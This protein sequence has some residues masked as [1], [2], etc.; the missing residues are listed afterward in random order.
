MQ[1]LERGQTTEYTGN[2]LYETKGESFEHAIFLI[3]HHFS[4]DVKYNDFIINLNALPILDQW[5]KLKR[6]FGEVKFQNLMNEYINGDY[7]NDQEFED[8]INGLFVHGI[9]TGELGEY[10]FGTNPTHTNYEQVRGAADVFNLISSEPVTD[11]EISYEQQREYSLEQMRNNCVYQ[12]CM[13]LAG[14]TNVNMNKYWVT[15][16]ETTMGI[17]R[18]TSNTV[19][20][21]ENTKVKARIILYLPAQAVYGE[22]G[23]L[24]NGFLVK[25]H[26]SNVLGD[27]DPQLRFVKASR[28]E[29]M[30]ER[31]KE[32]VHELI[33]DINRT[34]EPGNIEWAH[35]K[36]R[37]AD[38][39]IDIYVPFLASKEQTT[40]TTVG[41][42][43]TNARSET[44][45]AFH[46]WY[47][48]TSWADG[49]LHLSPMVYA[50]LEEA[51]NMVRFKWK[52]LRDVRLDYFLESDDIRAYFAR[53]VAFNIRT[54]DALS[55][56]RYHLNSTYPRVNHEKAKL[57]NVFR[58]IRLEG[59]TL[60]YHRV[61][62]SSLYVHGT[63][64]TEKYQDALAVADA[65][66]GSMVFGPSYAQ[67]GRWDNSVLN[68]YF[69]TIGDRYTDRLNV[70]YPNMM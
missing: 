14:F 12:F 63:T 20:T 50:H 42:N 53:L 31:S 24:E 29:Y 40:S 52:H 23:Y 27:F 44:T 67:M 5:K 64:Y 19:V 56:Q 68:R 51:H 37:W 10:T 22:H 41:G 21:R 34:V 65:R 70:A 6:K 46:R 55:G 26:R 62:S 25:Y 9:V 15:P 69:S 49:K 18:S 60:R 3:K 8:A 13:L 33:G 39:N 43:P 16:S 1:N 4:A 35:E 59:D 57:L 2:I 48:N 45:G 54:S 58:H 36:N 30:S 38:A 17:D 11:N 28:C 66:K 61:E 7:E 47:M 32:R